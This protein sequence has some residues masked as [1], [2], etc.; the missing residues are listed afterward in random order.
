MLVFVFL[1]QEVC[2]IG[3]NIYE[4]YDYS[5]IPMVGCFSSFTFLL[6]CSETALGPLSIFRSN[7]EELFSSDG[8]STDKIKLNTKWD[9]ALVGCRGQ[10]YLENFCIFWVQWFPKVIL[11]FRDPSFGI[12]EFLQDLCKTE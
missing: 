7:A 3:G 4:S 2:W 10:V 1:V 11:L 8:C 12:Q 5:I 9:T 6:I